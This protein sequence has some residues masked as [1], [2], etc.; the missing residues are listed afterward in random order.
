MRFPD[1]AILPTYLYAGKSS[2]RAIEDSIRV[3]RIES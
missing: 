2:Y 1:I 3:L